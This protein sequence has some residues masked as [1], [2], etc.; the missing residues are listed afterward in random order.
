MTRFGIVGGGLMG[1]G[2]AVA[3]ARAG[4]AAAVH[5]V[6]PRTLAALPARVRRAL[7]ECGAGGPQ[8]ERTAARVTAAPALG[9]LVR[10]ADVI[11]EAVPERLEVKH[12]V[13]AALESLAAPGTPVWTNTSVLSIT[14]VAEGM[15]HPGRLVGV[16]WW[17][18]PYLVPLVEV[19]PGAR[20]ERRLVD[21]ACALLAA[22]GRTT[23]RLRRDVP[24]FVGNRLQFALVREALHLLDQ[25]V[26]DP[27]TIDTVM[28]SSLGLRWS[29]VG[30]MENADYIGLELTRDI[31][32][33]LAPHLSS[34]T[35]AFPG[36]DVPLGEG[37]RGRSCGA[38]LLPW[39]PGRDAE[40]A[41]RLSAGIRRNLAGPAAAG[42][43]AP[44]PAT[45]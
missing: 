18:P 44:A 34:D 38:G 31:L 24:G 8:A 23:V 37:R 33:S 3:L 27:A 5:D 16:H 13:L 4:H 22:M 19:A 41:R 14:R 7:A 17:N 26:C 29:A 42:S 39:P 45:R 30:P 15:A 28:R 6:D 40:V 11:V 21:E 2:I 9:D 1:H 20:T 35:G 10:D 32:G 12:R 36:I 25:G 43:G